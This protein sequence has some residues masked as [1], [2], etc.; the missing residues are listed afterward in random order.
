MDLS[1]FFA[2]L[3]KPGQPLPENY[4]D[5]QIGA[6]IKAH[7]PGHFPDLDL[8][9]LALFSVGE[10]R[11]SVGNQGCDQGPS[12]IRKKLYELSWNFDYSWVDLGDFILGNHLSD[13]Y[14]GLVEVLGA[15]RKKGIFPLILGG[16]QDLTFPM[17][18]AFAAAEEKADLLVIDSH[19]DLADDMNLDD[20]TSSISYLHKI[21]TS[22][23]NYLFNFSNLGYQ[24]H[25]VGEESK[26]TLERMNFDLYRLGE[27][28]GNIADAEPIIRS[29]NS[30]SF[31][32]R[33]VRFSDA[34]G[35]VDQS[36]NGFY[37]EEACQLFRYA[38]MN[39]QLQSLGLFEYNPQF[40]HRDQSAGLLAQMIWYFLEGFGMRKVDNPLKSSN[41]FYKY[42]TGIKNNPMEIIFY[43][44]KKTGRWWM[45]VPYPAHYKKNQFYHLIP[46]RY[47]D[48]Q[49]ASNGEVPER[50]WKSYQ[51]L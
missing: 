23:P 27:I 2:P 13:T 29:A 10:D 31:D 14:A 37:G 38:G 12:Q 33:A 3:V 25:F 47:E 36:P 20:T 50:W 18:Q 49:Q 34:P 16:S 7:L 46:C 8:V 19:F 41:F 48:F 6:H 11:G 40:D 1:S 35:C 42:R 22:E 28:G 43:K 21:L 4:Y 17:Y 32:I 26:N 51:K 44:S 5:N 39:D 45:Q 9:Q 15:L 30:I 24:T